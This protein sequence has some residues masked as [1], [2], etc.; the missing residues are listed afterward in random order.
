MYANGA[1]AP[2]DTI[3]REGGTQSKEWKE[4]TRGLRVRRVVC[5][6]CSVLCDDGRRDRGKK[7][8]GEKETRS[9][10]TTCSAAAE[11]EEADILFLKHD[12]SIFRQSSNPV[13]GRA[14]SVSSMWAK[15]H[16]V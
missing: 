11:A 6:L 3:T 9:I 12:S 15:I 16:R 2:T 13:C 8:K 7:R 1:H 14:K 4:I 5:S 10:I